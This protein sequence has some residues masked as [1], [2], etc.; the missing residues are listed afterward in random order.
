M[1]LHVFC[2][3]MY[4]GK[5]SRMIGEVNRLADI[6]E[7][8]C[9]LIINYKGDIRQP[10]H[11]ISSHSSLYKGL[12]TK[13]TVLSTSA[14]SEIEISDYNIIGIDEAS[15]FPDLYKCV[16]EWISKGKHV[17]CAG[18]DSNFKMEPFDRGQIHLLLPIADQFIKL[19]AVCARCVEEIRLSGKAVNP[20]NVTP[21]P[22]TDKIAGNFDQEVEIGGSD[23]YIAVCRRHHSRYYQSKSQ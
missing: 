20:L 19:N 12:S 21:A 22:F 13:V 18:L 14:L 17:I 1:S 11:I 2:G 9:P 15:F 3:P 6:C 23:K 10:H 8:S 5:T 16:T 7:S 4:S